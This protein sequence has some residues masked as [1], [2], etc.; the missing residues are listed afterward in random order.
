MLGTTGYWFYQKFPKPGT[1]AAHIYLP[2]IVIKKQKQTPQLLRIVFDYTASSGVTV[3]DE[4]DGDT[5][6]EDDYISVAPLNQVGK[7]VTQGIEISPAIS[8]Q[9]QWQSDKVLVFIPDTPWPSGT[10]YSAN[11]NCRS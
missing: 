4:Q 6:K 11:G 2:S 8:G 1:L 7:T 3:P 5:I 9:W 10:Q